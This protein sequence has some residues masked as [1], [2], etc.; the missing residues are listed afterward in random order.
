MLSKV[1]KIVFW[2]LNIWAILCVLTFL[3]G[4]FVK[5]VGAPKW[6]P[7]PW[8]DFG[9]FVESSDENVFITINFYSRVICYN[10]DG[11]FVA[12][13][14]FPRGGPD[15]GL[16]SSIDGRI[17]FRSH[18]HLCVYDDSWQKILELENDS[19]RDINW[20]LDSSGNPVIYSGID[21]WVV[22]KLAQPGDQIFAKEEQ[23]K[24]FECGDGS[25]LVRDGN[26]LKKYNNDGSLQTTYS[27]SILFYPITFPWPGFLAWPYLFFLFILAIRRSRN[28]QHENVQLPTTTTSQEDKVYDSRIRERCFVSFGNLIRFRIIVLVLDDNGLTVKKLFKTI[29]IPKKSIKKICSIELEVCVFSTKSV[30]SIDYSEGG[31]IKHIDFASCD[32]NAWF[33]AFEKQGIPIEDQLNIRYSNTKYIKYAIY[34]RVFVNTFLATLIIVIVIIFVLMK[35]IL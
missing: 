31:N 1:K 26:S 8:S 24:K 32:N 13:Y 34:S 16:A 19:D 18:N 28:V 9:D 7:L 25:V 14:P 35:Y 20:I 21:Q 3:S 2:V 15:N 33:S 29:V 11:E 6:M 22:N 12:S 17:F 5:F 23:R 4:I 27:A 30:L 10:A